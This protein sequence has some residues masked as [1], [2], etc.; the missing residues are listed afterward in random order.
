LKLLKS[1]CQKNS[2][3]KFNIRIGKQTIADTRADPISLNFIT[4]TLSLFIQHS[5][6]S[7]SP[8]NIAY[9]TTHSRYTLKNLTPLK[10]FMSKIP[11]STSEIK[12]LSFHMILEFMSR[13]ESSFLR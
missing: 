11:L 1:G 8:A 3:G 4:L 6:S 9:H 10:I 7:Y 12:K 5:F 2:S 13:G